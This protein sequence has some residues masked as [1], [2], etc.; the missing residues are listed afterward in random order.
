MLTVLLIPGIDTTIDS[1]SGLVS[2]IS[3]RDMSPA[4][5]AHLRERARL[6][7]CS[8]SRVASELLAEASGLDGGTKKRDLSRF[9]GT[10]TAEEAAD[11][12]ATQGGFY[13]IDSEVW[14]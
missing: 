4:V 11:F 2:Q 5:E 14:A 10:W 12:E 9:A 8:L 7:G 6:E 3:I 1:R 13:A